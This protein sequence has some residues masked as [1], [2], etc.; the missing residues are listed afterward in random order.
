MARSSASSIQTIRINIKKLPRL[1]DNSRTYP[2][3]RMPSSVKHNLTSPHTSIHDFTTKSL[4][5]FLIDGDCD[6]LSLILLTIIVRHGDHKMMQL[7]KI[8]LL[9]P[10]SIYLS[11]CFF[12][13]EM[14]KVT[15]FGRKFWFW[16]WY[17]R[18]RFLRQFIINF[19]R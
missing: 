5:F 19:S 11:N 17:K 16:S 9:L 2:K 1:Y 10:Y 12:F 15:I 14:K 6:L 4:E 7:L 8:L 13:P 18:C 3:K